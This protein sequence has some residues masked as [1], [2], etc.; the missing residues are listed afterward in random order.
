[1]GISLLYSLN[2][3]KRGPQNKKPPKGSFTFRPLSDTGLFILYGQ[4]HINI[5]HQQF[6]AVGY[7]GFQLLVAISI[8]YGIFKAF[9]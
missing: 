1:M 8:Q 6:V 7:I 2:C 4:L 5:V 9:Q 3:R